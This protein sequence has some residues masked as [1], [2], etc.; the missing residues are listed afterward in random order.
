MFQGFTI[1]TS[2]NPPMKTLA[3]MVLAGVAVMACLLSSSWAQSD[4]AGL[5]KVLGQMD[6]AAKNFR[7]TEAGFVW[8]HYYVV[9][10]E[11]DESTSQKGRIYFRREN[12][13]IQMAADIAV[14][15][16]EY[17]LYTGGKVQV[18]QPKIEQVTEYSPGKSREDVESFLVLGFGGSGHDLLKSYDVKLV[19][20]ETVNGVA[21]EKLELIP[22]SEGLKKNIVRIV[23]WIDPARGISVQQQFFEPSGD[24]RL[25]KYSDIHVNQKL[26]DGV[27]K[28]KTSG[29]TKFVSPRG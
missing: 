3:K 15:D 8:D 21:S 13:D 25:A 10:K 24:Y 20:P 27:F 26:P 28:L 6:T 4:S 5:E 7:A 16:K 22:K 1:L 17:L 18:Y 19:G 12:G 14:P 2:E 11:I 9:L 23:L 29:K